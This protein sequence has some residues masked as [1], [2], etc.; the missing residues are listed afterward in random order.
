[1]LIMCVVQFQNLIVKKMIKLNNKGQALPLNTIVIALLVVVVLVVVIVAFT[2]NMGSSNEALANNAPT[3]ECSIENTAIS[4]LGYKEA[5]YS[6][7]NQNCGEGFTSLVGFG[8]EVTDGLPSDN[9][10]QLCCVG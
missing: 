2:S 8:R 5:K 1:M 7:S 10:R 9:G 6:S 3:K 4:A